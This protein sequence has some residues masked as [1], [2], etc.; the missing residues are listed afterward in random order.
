VAWDTERTDIKSG[1]IRSV[2][3][4]YLTQFDEPQHISNI[5]NYVLKYHPLSNKH[6]V[7]TNLRLANDKF[8]KFEQS[9][10]GLIDKEYATFGINPVPPFF[11]N[12]VM[13]F[14]M[15]H[16]DLSESDVVEALMAKYGLHAPQVTFI[17][18]NGVKAGS[19]IRNDGQL[20][21]RKKARKKDQTS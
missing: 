5:V 4:S 13:S 12:Q 3:K 16:P 19:L 8:K 20:K 21:A 9:Y 10:W 1:G 11:I 6:N 17:I 15:R 14:I 2:I 18:E 7:E